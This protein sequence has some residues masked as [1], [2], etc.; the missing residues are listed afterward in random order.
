MHISMRICWERGHFVSLPSLC[1]SIGIEFGR[2]FV[3]GYIE[4]G[5]HCPQIG[6][7]LLEVLLGSLRFQLDERTGNLGHGD[8][9]RQH[10]APRAHES[11]ILA[12]LGQLDDR[13]VTETFDDLLQRLSLANQ[14][15]EFRFGTGRGIDGRVR[16][17][18]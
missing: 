13:Y 6:Q 9:C 8:D 4:F 12:M 14:G 2:Q 3:F 1:N 7:R 18:V 15:L 5:Q 10:I 17:P 11:E 16:S